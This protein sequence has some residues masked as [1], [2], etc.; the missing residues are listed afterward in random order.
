[1]AAAAIGSIRREDLDLW[2]VAF[3]ISLYYAVELVFWS[4][5]LPFHQ[6]AAA[7]RA[8][9]AFETTEATALAMIEP[10]ERARLLARLERTL[11]DYPKAMDWLPKLVPLGVALIGVLVLVFKQGG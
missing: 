7:R 1:L 3:G 6:D 10:G 9:R 4:W 5:F 11:T 2:S 8:V